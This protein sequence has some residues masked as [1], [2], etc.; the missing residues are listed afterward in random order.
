[1]QAGLPA[2]GI[3]RT[4]PRTLV[5]APLEARGLNLP[6]LYMEQGIA[7]IE[8]IM[9]HGYQ[10]HNIMGK[11]IW[12]SIQQLKLEVGLPG[13]LLR[14][15]YSK[16]HWLAT[17]TWVKSV[18]HFLWEHSMQ[19]EDEAPHLE[20]RRERDQFLIKGFFAAGYRKNQLRILNRCC[21]Y[22]RATTL[23]DV[24]T[25]SGNILKH[26]AWHGDWDNTQ[27]SIY[28]WPHQQRPSEAEW[29]EWRRALTVAF[30]VHP[31]HYTLPVPLS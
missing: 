30:G 1:M 19:I 15:D 4:F 26:N 2:L 3:A 7:H 16:Y 9:V 8:Q 10:R 11:L 31:H 20:L 18:W 14:Q 23:A 12:G 5:H 17:D 29:V 6:D 27:E 13:A 28:R 22:L 21:L 24:T 25:G